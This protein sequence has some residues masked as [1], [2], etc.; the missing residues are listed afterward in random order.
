MDEFYQNYRSAWRPLTRDTVLNAT[1][2][3]SYDET[4]KKNKENGETPIEKILEQ[5]DIL[6]K[7]VKISTDIDTLNQMILDQ[8]EKI[9]NLLS[10]LEKIDAAGKKTVFGLPRK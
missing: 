4:S 10:L 5:T 9:D 6:N 8:S 1:S 3:S 2:T 7:L